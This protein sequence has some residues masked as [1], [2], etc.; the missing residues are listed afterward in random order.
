M[1]LLRQLRVLIRIIKNNEDFL[2]NKKNNLFLGGKVFLFRACPTWNL[3][4]NQEEEEDAVNKDISRLMK[5]WHL[6]KQKEKKYPL[7]YYTSFLFLFFKAS[8]FK[9]CG[10]HLCALSQPG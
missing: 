2:M 3:A 7:L 6:K 1:F 10:Q 8:A 5:S 9:F 4:E